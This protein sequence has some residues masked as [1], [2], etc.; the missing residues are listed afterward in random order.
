MTV[1]LKVLQ[2]FVSLQAPSGDA[3]KSFDLVPVV[4]DDGRQMIVVQF[5][6]IG[7]WRR[8]RKR[9]RNFLNTF[10]AKKLNRFTA[11]HVARSVSTQPVIHGRRNS[12]PA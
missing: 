3:G 9:G 8:R 2:G 11:T 7:E 10:Y 5:R 4:R 1:L 12:F 6:L